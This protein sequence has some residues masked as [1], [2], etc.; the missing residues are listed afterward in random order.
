VPDDLLDRAGRVED[1][2]RRDAGDRAAEDHARDVAARLGRAQTDVLEPPPDLGD[3]LDADPVQLD[4]VPIGE[5]GGVAG[6][7]GRDPADG[8]ELLGR[9]GAAVHPHPEH[10]VAVLELVRLERRGPPAVD[11]GFAL[12]VQAPP[13]EAS[14]QVVVGD[15]VEALDR[16]DA[17]DAFAHVE[18]VVLGLH[19]LAR[20]ERA[21]TVDGPLAVRAGGVRSRGR[22]LGGGRTGRGEGAGGRGSDRRHGGARFL[23][24]TGRPHE[25]GR[26]GAGARGRGD[27]P[28][29][30]G[31]AWD[32]AVEGR[33]VEGRGREGERELT[34]RRRRSG[35]RRRSGRT[36]VAG[37]RGRVLRSATTR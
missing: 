28:A 1:L 31:P 15:R 27:R 36:G 29:W 26:P 14:V 23:R 6:E 7:L 4:V 12:R 16:V 13:A 25:G 8:A 3:V 19:R 35:V 5:V 11:P 9:Q 10:E 20:V 18:A 24:G 2:V 21:A 30:D 32:R 22:H 34:W 37:G 17:L 33:A